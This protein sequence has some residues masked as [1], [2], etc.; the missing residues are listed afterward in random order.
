VGRKERRAKFWCGPAG[1]VK[2]KTKNGHHFKQKP[3]PHVI[4]KQ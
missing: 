2:M 3:L 1:T 4:P